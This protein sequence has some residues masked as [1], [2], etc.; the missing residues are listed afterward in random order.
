MAHQ[1]ES[2]ES[3]CIAE[4]CSEAYENSGCHDI[5]TFQN[6]DSVNGVLLR[7]PEPTINVPNRHFILNSRQTN[8][9]GALS[10]AI[11]N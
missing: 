3:N 9:I 2:L 4:H 10:F 8:E 11:K 1:T 7:K 6:R 5:C